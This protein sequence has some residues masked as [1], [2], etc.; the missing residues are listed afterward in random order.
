M[1]GNRMDYTGSGDAVTMAPNDMSAIFNR[2]SETT[3]FLGTIRNDVEKTADRI[4]GAMPKEGGANKES[5]KSFS[6]MDEV[7]A[8]LDRL[9]ATAH[10]LNEQCTRLHRL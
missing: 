3:D 5:D 8:A 10:A 6:Q 9:N 7:K 1:K 4:Y 2:I